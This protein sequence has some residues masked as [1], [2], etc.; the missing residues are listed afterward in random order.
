MHTY[1]NFKNCISFMCLN[2]YNTLLFM[3]IIFY[4]ITYTYIIIINIPRHCIEATWDIHLNNDIKIATPLGIRF[5]H[6][7]IYNSFNQAFIKIATTPNTAI[8]TAAN[9]YLYCL[10]SSWHSLWPAPHTK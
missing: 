10:E 4:S 5:T 9:C 2:T 7:I 1:V 3:Q 8:S 6:S